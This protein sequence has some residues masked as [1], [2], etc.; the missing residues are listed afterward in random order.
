[1]ILFG[2]WNLFLLLCYSL[3]FS[4]E[5]NRFSNS[6]LHL[7][8]LRIDKLHSLKGIKKRYL[9]LVR[10]LTCIFFSLFLIY[11]LIMLLQLSLFRPFTQLHPARPLPPTFPPYSS[12]PWVILISSLASTFPTSFRMEGKIKCF[13]DKFKLKEFIIAKPLLYEMLKGLT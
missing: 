13:S 6:L 7:H 4:Y 2:S 3:K 8:L 1:M 9:I 10:F 5:V 11:L 12:C